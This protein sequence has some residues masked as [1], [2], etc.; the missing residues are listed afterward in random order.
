MSMSP[1]GQQ[2]WRRTHDGEIF[3]NEERIAIVPCVRSAKAEDDQ[4]A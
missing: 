3:G 4:V 2:Y 1:T